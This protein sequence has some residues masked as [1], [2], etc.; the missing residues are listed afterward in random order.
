MGLD[1]KNII[2]KYLELCESGDSQIYIE[3]RYE[4]Y[5]AYLDLI[6]FLQKES[7]EFDMRTQYYAEIRTLIIENYYKNHI[8]T[9]AYW[10]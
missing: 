3:F 10:E 9:A 5:Y 6:G 7:V 4:Q 8:N 1:N 2:D